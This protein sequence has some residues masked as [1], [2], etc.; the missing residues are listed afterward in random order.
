MPKK[1]TPLLQRLHGNIAMPNGPGC[2]WI[3][4]RAKRPGGYG[5]THVG[6][7]TWYVHRL[8]HTLYN[9]PI[10]EGYEIDHLCNQPPCCNPAHLEAVTPK[11]NKRRKRERRTHCS[12]GHE[13]NAKNTRTTTTRH[14]KTQRSCRI[15][16]AASQRR[17]AKRRKS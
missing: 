6:H 4:Q 10:P 14:G 1:A 17:Y 7:K 15:C 2:C 9:G 5:I 8:T 12:N 3:W 16:Q 11:E 13:Y